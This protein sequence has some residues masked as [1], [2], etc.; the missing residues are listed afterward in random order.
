MQNLLQRAGVRK[1][2]LDLIPDIVDT[3]VACRAWHRPLPDAQASVS[4]SDTFNEEVEC[5]LLFIYNYI[6]FHLIDRCIR[7]HVARVVKG[8]HA[9]DLI[10]V[11]DF[12]CE[13]YGPMKKL[14]V[15]GERGIVIATETKDF[16]NQKGIT[17]CER[18]PGMHGRY[19]ERRGAMLRDSIHRGK[20]QCDA[21]GITV[22]FERLLSEIY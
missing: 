12:W 10:P 11:I 13:M 7:W 22:S 19:I 18:A 2:V 15:D 20:S 17:I 16:C 6:V 3:C 4:L 8:K 5:D 1:E 21:E 9:R 14:I